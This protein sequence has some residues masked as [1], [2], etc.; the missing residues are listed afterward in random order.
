MSYIFPIFIMGSSESTHGFR[1]IDIQ[2]NS[3]AK[4][5]GL[6]S[7]LDFIVSANGIHLQPNGALHNIISKSLKCRVFLKVFNILTQEIREVIVIPSNE[8]GG[9]GLLGASLRWED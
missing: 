4:S 8:W 5:A 7:Y 9:D 2:L 1:V 3:P 6:I